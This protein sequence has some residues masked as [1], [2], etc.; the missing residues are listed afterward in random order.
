MVVMVSSSIITVSTLWMADTQS[1]L[2]QLVRHRMETFSRWRLL[3]I[4]SQEDRYKLKVNKEKSLPFCEN[5]VLQG[6][7]YL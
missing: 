3:E 1:I 6:L 4:F 7:H 2:H 5:I